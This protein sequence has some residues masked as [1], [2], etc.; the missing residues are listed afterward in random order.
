MRIGSKWPHLK[1][2]LVKARLAWQSMKRPD[3]N[4]SVYLLR[5]VGPVVEMKEPNKPALHWILKWSPVFCRL[6]EDCTVAVMRVPTFFSI[7]YLIFHISY[8]IF[9]MSYLILAF[10]SYFGISAANRK[11]ALVQVKAALSFLV[12]YVRG[13][14]VRQ[15]RDVFLAS[16]YI[17]NLEPILN[18][19][20]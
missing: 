13:S 20:N 2:T 9:H 19:V 4:L 3:S 12:I 5:L 18:F 1:E 17:L 6:P 10:A 11:P 14:L 8:I 15:S 7:S 16:C